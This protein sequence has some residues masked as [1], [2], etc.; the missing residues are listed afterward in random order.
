MKLLW[1][2][3]LLIWEKN[4]NTFSHLNSFLPLCFNVCLQGQDGKRERGER[5]KKE[6][7]GRERGKKERRGEKEVR[8]RERK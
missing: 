4:T 2:D 8:E 3:H 1:K 6:R 7:K 5:E